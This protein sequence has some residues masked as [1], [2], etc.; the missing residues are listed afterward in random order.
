MYY[1]NLIKFKDVTSN[2][3]E[4]FTTAIR[5]TPDGTI[6]P[7]FPTKVFTTLKSDTSS[8]YQSTL[9]TSSKYLS[10]L[11]TSS[12]T[13]L[14]TSKKQSTSYS[15]TLFT[16]PSIFESTLVNIPS[17]TNYLPSLS[18]TSEPAISIFTMLTTSKIL[19]T[20]FTPTLFTT[21]R[22]DTSQ[23]ITTTF[24]FGSIGMKHTLT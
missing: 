18:I 20:S 21:L 5:T 8:I 22:P 12:S 6:H 10:T 14:T 24:I 1:I 9:L 19:A 15:S 11:V 17:S 23:G 4:N 3:N 16:T 13:M 7:T 2:N